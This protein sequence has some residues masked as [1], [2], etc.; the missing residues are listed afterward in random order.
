MDAK[1]GDVRSEVVVRQ[2]SCRVEMF[3]L[4]YLLYL[5]ALL[6]DLYICSLSC[7]RAKGGQNINVKLIRITSAARIHFVNSPFRIVRASNRIG[8]EL[9]VKNK[10]MNVH[11]SKQERVFFCTG[12][13]LYLQPA[14]IWIVYSAKTLCWSIDSMYRVVIFIYS[15]GWLWFMLEEFT[16][17]LLL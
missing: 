14:N 6:L 9:V 15:M 3:A 10:L 2:T 1:I 12:N 16:F 7:C 11:F 13:V 8:G 17:Q 5:K 4:L